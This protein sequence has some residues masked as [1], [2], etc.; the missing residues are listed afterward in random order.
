MKR[1]Q[2]VLGVGSPELDDEVAGGGADDHVRQFL[3]RFEC[4][5]PALPL[6]FDLV[7]ENPVGN[8]LRT[9]ESVLEEDLSQVQIVGAF[10]LPRR[11]ATKSTE[12][13]RTG[14]GCRDARSEDWVKFPPG[15]ELIGSPTEIR[16]AITW[17]PR[18]HGCSQFNLRVRKGAFDM[19]KIL[20]CEKSEAVC[21]YARGVDG[22]GP[23]RSRY[24]LK[25]QH[26]NPFGECVKDFQIPLRK[27]SGHWV[28]RFGEGLGEGSE[29]PYPEY[30]TSPE[31]LF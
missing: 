21:G 10:N 18:C 4:L 22:V 20:V 1:D 27:K 6:H 11:T 30:S 15:L 2:F 13:I 8:Q 23:P 3:S 12:P 28:I 5:S 16:L 17:P 9:S 14:L 7:F 26:A 29:R 24:L 19:D 25:R 31:L